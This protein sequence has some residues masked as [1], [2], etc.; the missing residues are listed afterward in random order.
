MLL[1]IFAIGVIFG[2]ICLFIGYS[3]SSFSFAYLGMFIFLI[4]GMFL[5]QEGLQI[6]TGATA[7]GNSVVTD[8]TVLTT[9]SSPIVNVVA[10][11]FFYIP[12]AGVL[13]TTL[14]T[15]RG[16]RTRY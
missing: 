8:Y 9:Q 7:I 14:L 16:W 5:T 12:L 3:Q 6:A 10:T 4:T 2:A 13:L 11:T 15:L 1:E